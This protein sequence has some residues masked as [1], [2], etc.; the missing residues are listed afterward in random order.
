MGDGL[1]LKVVVCVFL[2]DGD[3]MGEGNGDV[4]E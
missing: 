1:C 4:G 2:W 3:G